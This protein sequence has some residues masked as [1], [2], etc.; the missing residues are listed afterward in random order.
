LLGLK[1]DLTNITKLQAQLSYDISAY[2]EGDSEEGYNLNC[3]LSHRLSNFTDLSG[4][5]TFGLSNSASSD[6][7]R[8]Q[9]HNLNLSLNHQLSQRLSLSLGT[10]LGMD[11]YFKEDYIGTGGPED[12]E[13][14]QY[15]FNFGL[16]HRLYNWLSLNFRYRHSRLLSEFPDEG[17][18]ENV[19][20][21]GATFNF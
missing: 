18:I 20:S 17:Y 5:Y 9:Q 10:T 6:Y 4:T 8:Y 2:E 15:G 21:W 19:Y 7:R 3:S 16:N 13:R 12:K 1:Y 14:R 11:N